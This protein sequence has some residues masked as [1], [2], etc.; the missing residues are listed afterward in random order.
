MIARDR[1]LCTVVS[2]PGPREPGLHLLRIE[3]SV[4]GER[5][6]AVV[7]GRLIVPGALGPAAALAKLHALTLTVA[8]ELNQAVFTA[9]SSDRHPLATNTRAEL[10]RA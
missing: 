2:G 4:A 1:P 9:R 8:S 3:A 5:L 6:G 7:S 10:Q